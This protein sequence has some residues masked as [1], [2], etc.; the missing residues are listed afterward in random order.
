MGRGWEAEAEGQKA[1]KGEDEIQA[2][3]SEEPQRAVKTSR[4]DVRSPGSGTVI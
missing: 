1:G 2:L 4:K 3:M